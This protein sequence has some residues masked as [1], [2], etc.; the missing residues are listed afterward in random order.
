MPCKGLYRITWACY[1]TK[2]LALS[3]NHPFRRSLMRVCSRVPATVSVNR[4]MHHTHV[5]ITTGDVD[6]DVAS[7]AGVEAHAS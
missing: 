5:M 4:L 7:T 2:P 3:T 1:E 6:V